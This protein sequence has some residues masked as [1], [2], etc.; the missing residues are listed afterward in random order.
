MN[1][2]EISS[3]NNT[4][5]I[6]SSRKNSMSE[7]G[8]STKETYRTHNSIDNQ[9]NFDERFDTKNPK[10]EK[11]KKE[12]KENFINRNTLSNKAD[13]NNN[14]N[15]VNSNQDL[16]ENE[17][18]IEEKSTAV[19]EDSQNVV[20]IYKE[21]KDR[22][23]L[24][25][26][27]SFLAFN[28][29]LHKKDNSILE[30]NSC[31]FTTTNQSLIHGI[32]LKNDGDSVKLNNDQIESQ[33]FNSQLIINK[34]KKSENYDIIPIDLTKDSEEKELKNCN[35]NSNKKNNKLT[36]NSNN[37]L[38]LSLQ[39]QFESIKK[40]HKNFDR[41]VDYCMVN[42]SETKMLSFDEEV[43]PESNV[44]SLDKASNTP[45]NNEKPINDDISLNYEN[46]LNN[47]DPSAVNTDNFPKYQTNFFIS[48][49]DDDFPVPNS[50]IKANDVVEV[51]DNNGTIQKARIIR[52]ELD[53]EVTTATNELSK[54]N[55]YC[56][57]LVENHEDIASNLFKLGK[58]SEK[59]DQNLSKK[60][61]VHFMGS[62]KRMDHWISAAKILRKIR[63]ETSFNPLSNKVSFIVFFIFIKNLH[64]LGKFNS[65]I[66]SNTLHKA[67][68]MLKSPGL[69]NLQ[70]SM[71]TRK[72]SNLNF[73]EEGVS[74]Y[75][76]FNL[77]I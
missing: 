52:V 26:N 67:S 60:F 48:L 74:I 55:S 11:D 75:I 38:T 27:D 46:N 47:N 29:A 25:N 72:R 45:S 24:E 41:K 14:F 42:S 34:S 5:L 43:Q 33:A 50:P 16:F 28:Y 39:N 3:I 13:V 8:P 51:Y 9:M 59:A 66:V 18:E 30:D 71:L 70:N 77:L 15:R 32:H 62:E 40:Q 69:I 61:Y 12:G 65:G 68:S 63:D 17:N 23:T 57:S 31:L 37:S 35:D 19:F 54:S 73:N 36:Q 6:K 4:S 53:D 2:N 58:K 20:T 44:N 49:E 7:K 21:H 76:S 22:V 56:Q 1:L 10:F 64:K